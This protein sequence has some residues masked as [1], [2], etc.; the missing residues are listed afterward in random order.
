MITLITTFISSPLIITLLTLFTK[1]VKKKVPLP[2]NNCKKMSPRY[3]FPFSRR[4]V[5]CSQY[6]SLNKALV[7][8]SSCAVCSENPGLSGRY[9]AGFWSG[10]RWSCCR[11]STRSAEGCDTCSSWSTSS[12]PTAAATA[13]TAGGLTQ[14][15]ITASIISTERQQ[16]QSGNSVTATTTLTTSTTNS[17]S[18]ANN[19]PIVQSQT[20]SN[21]GESLLG[22]RFQTI[23]RKILCSRPDNIFTVKYGLFDIDCGLEINYNNLM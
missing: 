1:K 14:P 23:S 9:H 19:N 4:E 13:T 16:Q 21:N 5:C 12:K 7:C 8:F 20:R 11:M 2:R 10:K 6:K 3:L 15:S 17:C 18:E 22:F